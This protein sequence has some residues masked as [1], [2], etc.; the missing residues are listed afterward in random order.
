MQTYTKIPIVFS[1]DHNFVMP[2][3]VAI[4]SLIRNS[5]YEVYAIYILISSDVDE[6]DKTELGSIVENTDSEITFIDTNGAFDNAYEVRGISKVT[7]FR[8]IIPWL[9]PQYDKIIY[10]DV[11]IVFRKGLQSL[12]QLTIE[13]NLICGVKDSY[14][15]DEFIK[16]LKGLGLN[17]DNYIN[18]GFIVINSKLWREEN[19]LEKIK[20]HIDNNYEY[21]DQD[22]I[23]IVCKNRI[24][25]ISPVYNFNANGFAGMNKRYLKHLSR[26][27]LS[28]F[29]LLANVCVIHYCG[30]KP[31]RGR[32]VF[33]SFEWFSNFAQTI[34]YNPEMEFRAYTEVTPKWYSVFKS[35]KRH[36]YKLN[37]K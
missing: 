24:K 7:Y 9:L 4:K 3:G 37:S 32:G 30:M 25:Y 34:W 33:L 2:T 36:L 20:L 1:T 5:S 8:L 12:Y 11:D 21:Q 28:K 23:N 17:W 22:I 29:S 15:D 35:I 6:H 19:L 16:Y 26:F 13:D 18:A 10:S 14:S 31:W 27:G